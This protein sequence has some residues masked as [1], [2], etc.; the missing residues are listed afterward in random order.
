VLEHEFQQINQQILGFKKNG[1]SVPDELVDKKQAYEL[2]M[3]ILVTLIQIGK[4]D[5]DGFFS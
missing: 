1:K 2:R 3:N 5:M 4:L